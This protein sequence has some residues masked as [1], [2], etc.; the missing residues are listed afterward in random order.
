MPIDWLALRRIRKLPP[1]SRPTLLRLLDFLFGRR[2]S[3]GAQVAAIGNG[4]QRTVSPIA[5]LGIVGRQHADQD[6][7]GATSSGG[8][9]IPPLFAMDCIACTASSESSLLKS[10]SSSSCWSLLLTKRCVPP[11]A[12]ASAADASG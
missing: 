3:F 11:V 7:R 6:R 10:S 1:K 2:F 12:A 5:R 8:V 4:Q 9:I